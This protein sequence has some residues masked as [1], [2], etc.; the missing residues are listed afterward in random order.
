MIYVVYLCIVNC[1]I[2]DFNYGFLGRKFHALQKKGF[3]S[4]CR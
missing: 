3:D 4:W 2:Q 1:N